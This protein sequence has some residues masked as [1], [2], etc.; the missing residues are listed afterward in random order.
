[1]PESHCL[2][3][4]VD[5]CE[6]IDGNALAPLFEILDQCLDANLAEKQLN[7]G[8]LGS[9]IMKFF[10][11]V[12]HELLAIDGKQALYVLDMYRK[13]WVVHVPHIPNIENLGDYFR[14]RT[15]DFGIRYVIPN[16]DGILCCSNLNLYIGPTGPCLN[17]RWAPT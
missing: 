1:M 13:W 10:L 12:L 11:P 14:H 17:S 3:T 2:I 5:V 4:T 8:G 7:Q 6:S 9:K 15:L 16:L